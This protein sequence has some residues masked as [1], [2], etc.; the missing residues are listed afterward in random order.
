MFIHTSPTFELIELELR[1][2]QANQFFKADQ[3]IVFTLQSGLRP[4]QLTSPSKF[5]GRER[6]KLLLTG[7]NMITC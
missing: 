1:S 5:N 6:S 3:N 2:Y 7:R 4:S